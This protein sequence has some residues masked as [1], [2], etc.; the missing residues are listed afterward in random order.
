MNYTIEHINIIFKLFED[1]VIAIT[2]DENTLR[3]IC[4]K[5]LEKLLKIA[6]LVK[7]FS[8]D[9]IFVVN[10]SFHREN[11]DLIN[12]FCICYKTSRIPSNN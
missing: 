10:L 5:N 2:N 3:K 8:F 6:F 9:N 4:F 7:H 1:S 11:K 12:N